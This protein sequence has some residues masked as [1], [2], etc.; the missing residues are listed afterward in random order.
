MTVLRK[1]AQ[2]ILLD[3]E[4]QQFSFWIIGAGVVLVALPEYRLLRAVLTD[5]GRIYVRTHDPQAGQLAAAKGT[6][7]TAKAG[8][9][10][11][12]EQ[13]HLY[14]G[15]AGDNT[16]KLYVTRDGGSSRCV[17][18]VVMETLDRL[19]GDEV[20]TFLNP[21]ELL[22]GEATTASEVNYDFNVREETPI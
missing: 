17:L 5:D 12:V 13:M 18:Q 19:V 22:E 2:I 3:D 11:Y 7:H 10:S 15:G 20:F 4:E 1:T 6:L 8:A 21:G 9:H 16:V 14:N